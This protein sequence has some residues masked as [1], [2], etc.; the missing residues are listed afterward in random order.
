MADQITVSI[1]LESLRAA[2]EKVGPNIRARCLAAAFITASAIKAN[3]QSA[4]AKRRGVTYQ[5][6]AIET[7]RVGDGYVVQMDPKFKEPSGGSS[8]RQRSK[9]GK[10][11]GMKH[12]GSW[13]EF[14]RIYQQP[15][16]WL[17]PAANAQESAYLQ[18]ITDAVQRSLDEVQG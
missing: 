15:R 6:V 2:F 13:L 1:D 16:P 18:R 14:G 9:T 8:G 12:V 3:A 17:F 7:R 4:M 10:G 11:G 5:H